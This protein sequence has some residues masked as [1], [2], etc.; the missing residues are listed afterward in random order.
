M[1]RILGLFM[2]G[3]FSLYAIVAYEA[4][5]A[6]I[7]G[8]QAPAY[9]VLAAHAAGIVAGAKNV[10]EEEAQPKAVSPSRQPGVSAP[11]ERSTD[12][13]AVLRPW[14]WRRRCRR[15]Q[16]MELNAWY[17][18]RRRARRRL[19]RRRRLAAAK[20]RRLAS[21]PRQHSRPS[22]RGMLWQWLALAALAGLCFYLFGEETA[23][24]ALAVPT[25]TSS[26]EKKKQEL[27]AKREHLVRSGQKLIEQVGASVKSATS[28]KLW[29]TLKVFNSSDKTLTGWDTEDVHARMLK[30]AFT[31]DDQW[32]SA[33]ARHW[34]Q[35]MALTYKVSQKAGNSALFDA[36]KW[37]IQFEDVLFV[38][39]LKDA[40]GND[41]EVEWLNSVVGGMG[42]TPVT[43]GFWIKERDEDGNLKPLAKW[44]A[45]IFPNYK[46][47]RARAR[48]MST[49]P[50]IAP[51][52]TTACGK[53]TKFF[54]GNFEKTGQVGADGGNDFS[55]DLEFAEIDA[56][57][58]QVRIHTPYFEALSDSHSQLGL[59]GKGQAH[60]AEVKARKVEGSWKRV[61]RHD[62]F[63]SADV[64]GVFLHF[65]NI[66]GALSKEVEAAVMALAPDEFIC[67]NDW[68]YENGRLTKLLDEDDRQLLGGVIAEDNL[69]ASSS[70]SWQETILR[71]LKAMWAQEDGWR[72]QLRKALGRLY[73]GESETLKALF[74]ETSTQ[75]AAKALAGLNPRKVDHI[76]FGAG[77]TMRT[78]YCE[79]VSMPGRYVV[80]NKA[81]RQ[82]KL[83]KDG[84][85]LVTL[86]GQ[87][88]LYHHCLVSARVVVKEDVEQAF[89]VAAKAAGQSV[90]TAGT[91]TEMR[92]TAQVFYAD[93]CKHVSDETGFSGDEL[94]LEVFKR[95]RSVYIA[96][97]V[98]PNLI[99]MAKE[100]QD[101]LQRDSDGDRILFDFS[102][103]A[104]EACLLHEEAIRNLPMPR[105]EVHKSSPLDGDSEVMNLKPFSYDSNAELKARCLLY[106]CAPNQGQGPTGFAVNLCSAVLGH[107]LWLD[108][109]DGWGPDPEVREATLRFYATL[110]L[111]VQNC[112][113]RTKK[114]WEPISLLRWYLTNYNKLFT[115]QV[116]AGTDYPVADFVEGFWTMEAGGD[117]YFRNSRLNRNEQ[118]NIPALK[119]FVA[120]TLNFI[121]V[122][123]SFTTPECWADDM[124][125]IAKMFSA[126]PDIEGVDWEAI[127]TRLGCE[128]SATLAAGWVWPDRL[129]GWKKEASLEV[130]LH[131]APPALNLLSEWAVEEN[132]RIRQEMGVS[133]SPER[134]V[135]RDCMLAGSSEQHKGVIMGHKAF[136]VSLCKSYKRCKAGEIDKM[137]Q[138]EFFTNRGESDANRY[139]DLLKDAVRDLDYESAGR[140]IAYAAL[141]GKFSNE[142]LTKKDAVLGLAKLL[143]GVWA[144]VGYEE[145]MLNRKPL[146]YLAF[147]AAKT[148]LDFI[149][150][151]DRIDA[152]E[153]FE[154]K[155][156]TISVEV[157]AAKLL[158]HLKCTSR[159]KRADA[160]ASGLQEVLVEAWRSG[161]VI[162]VQT[163]Q[164]VKHI[165]PQTLT[166]LRTLLSSMVM[167]SEVT[168]WSELIWSDFMPALDVQLDLAE[169][170]D[171]KKKF[172]VDGDGL[173][174]MMAALAQD[175]SEPEI[176]KIFAAIYKQLLTLTISKEAQEG[177]ELLLEEAKVLLKNTTR[178]EKF[179]LI[180]GY[181]K[182]KG[183]M[184]KARQLMTY[185]A[186]LMQGLRLKNLLKKQFKEK[187][188]GDEG[189]ALLD[190]YL[191]TLL[192][193]EKLEYRVESGESVWVANRRL[194]GRVDYPVSSNLIAEAA[195][196][197]LKAGHSFYLLQPTKN[198]WVPTR[199][200][201]EGKMQIVAAKRW[202][203]H[204]SLQYRIDSLDPVE[205]I[206]AEF[207]AEFAIGHIYS[208]AELRV[209]RDKLL[210]PRKEAKGDDFE[211]S[212]WLDLVETKL[213]KADLLAKFE[214]SNNVNAVVKATKDINAAFAGDVRLP[215][216]WGGNAKWLNGGWGY[217][218]SIYRPV[219]RYIMRQTEGL[220]I[221]DD[222]LKE[223]RF[224]MFEELTG[225]TLLPG[226]KRKKNLEINYDRPSDAVDQLVNTFVMAKTEEFK[227]QT[228]RSNNLDPSVNPV[229]CLVNTGKLGAWVKIQKS[230]APEDVGRVEFRD[231]TSYSLCHF[232]EGDNAGKHVIHSSLSGDIRV[233]RLDAEM[234]RQQAVRA[235]VRGVGAAVKLNGMKLASDLLNDLARGV[236][237]DAAKAEFI[238]GLLHTTSVMDSYVMANWTAHADRIG[239][240][241]PSALKRM[242]R[243]S[244]EVEA[245]LPADEYFDSLIKLTLKGGEK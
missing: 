15:L 90:K 104:V 83:D 196:G 40:S 214:W 46:E 8:T 51:I 28:S 178:E 236:N 164:G 14:V 80:F 30:L 241:T 67:L 229:G 97:E 185:G 202:V 228:R 175:A 64:S 106:V 85:P 81:E 233:T 24:L 65:D 53:A 91:P 75:S 12:L 219:W 74:S 3:L 165:G 111:I 167:S 162:S 10:I 56:D 195:G 88:Q 29:F 38:Q 59:Q 122:G 182:S 22:S 133:L 235:S 55:W 18:A 112:I 161:E 115:E 154:K 92:K 31:A 173:N 89:F 149:D 17:K 57:I 48:G 217:R 143:K 54:V 4:V 226:G 45:A 183:K 7:E 77:R 127:A 25:P 188:Q 169:T 201:N 216:H 243:I 5:G 102:P 2:F 118:Y 215:Y 63:K 203:A 73:R 245:K 58:F 6:A 220:N 135:Y 103:F 72:N 126:A 36:L 204:D 109:E 43:P 232:L 186:P 180:V 71:S 134:T 70:V 9:D 172:F 242:F 206:R 153:T 145:W 150:I 200:R 222:A 105:P 23:G 128:D 176:R 131:D 208:E 68:W 32:S 230:P 98:S 224:E 148:N 99:W 205:I 116:V 170:S 140:S 117:L 52:N 50:I 49:T 155:G 113:D 13:V 221:S 119:L 171:V 76:V 239:S 138:S 218:S 160:I 34:E 244:Q 163:L 21:E 120:W 197:L 42:Y 82:A 159:G 130:P 152:G 157:V 19:A 110:V 193:D 141:I 211:F 27:E 192:F 26:K 87:P 179:H 198:L 166:G 47:L 66:K 44:F 189:K 146:S 41:V 33:F 20:Q 207:A 60:K 237:G 93:L 124:A 212:A 86:T 123:Y 181:L 61:Y 11:E 225:A 142:K 144:E 125:F 240:K 190:T 69:S 147:N 121:K 16:A 62:G 184:P 210:L 139:L 114:P 39:N 199:G 107:I 158:I 37:D 231:S 35:L 95:I 94:K 101:R 1:N 227:G 234:F 78:R 136:V 191:K 84:F 209:L 96:I 213:S 174:Q 100:T 151:L 187:F 137:A 168:H 79:Q 108:S 129:Y 156:D 194:R 132:T 177:G 223:K 238:I